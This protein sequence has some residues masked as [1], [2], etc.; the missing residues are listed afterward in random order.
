MFLGRLS[1]V[2]IRNSNG[3]TDPACSLIGNANTA[4]PHHVWLPVWSFSLQWI[5]L[6]PHYLQLGSF[7]WLTV[8]GLPQ[9][10]KNYICELVF[11][12]TYCVKE[13]AGLGKCRSVRTNQW[14]TAQHVKHFSVWDTTH[15]AAAKKAYMEVQSSVLSAEWPR[16][17]HMN[18]SKIKQSKLLQ[19]LFSLTKSLPTPKHKY[20]SLW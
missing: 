12:I 8:P 2:N 14:N 16:Q 20:T 15:E 3:W 4:F 10:L 18:P 19:Q 9:A 13:L 17:H 1:A 5:C 7:Y 11:M 6:F